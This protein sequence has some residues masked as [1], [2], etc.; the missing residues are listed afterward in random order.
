[1]ELGYSG[2]AYN[3]CMKGVMSDNDRCTIYVFPLSSLLKASPTLSVKFYREL[4]KI[5]FDH[6]CKASE[7]DL[8]AIAF[9]E[10]LPSRL[11]QLSKRST[12]K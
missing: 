5:V 7:V 8:I 4:L 1:M 9:S 3:R 11:L 2:V 12:S 10:R 6:V